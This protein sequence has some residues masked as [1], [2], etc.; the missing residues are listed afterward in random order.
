MDEPQSRD[1]KRAPWRWVLFGVAIALT[2]TW[3]FLTPR[4]LLG[5]ADAVGYAVCHQIE[6][7]SF[8]INGRSF[9][10]CARCSGLFLGALLGLI[11]Q[12]IQGRKGRMPPLGASL[13]FGL[14]AFA[15]VFDGFN[16]FLMLVPSI[17]SLYTTQ[18]WTRLVTGTGM[19]LAVSAFL[20]PAFIQ[21]MFSTWEDQSAFKG[22]KSIS[23][24]VLAAVGLDLILLLEVSWIL[25]PLA[26]L[27]AGG[28]LVLL[29]MVYSTVLV[30][31]FKRDNTYHNF[32]A[33]LIPLVGGYIL[34]LLQIGVIDLVRYLLTGT[35]GGFS[36]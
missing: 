32:R 12:V 24:V 9:P 34:A 16:S 10:L 29:I 5:K 14:L 28:V 36:L 22:W 1:H 21:T 17:S 27:S 35:W 7:R 6:A 18:N 20:M 2:V 33:L 30:M 15:W 4:G 25:Y 31:L 8:Q 26:L 3:L 13:F 23:I 11:Y 19:G